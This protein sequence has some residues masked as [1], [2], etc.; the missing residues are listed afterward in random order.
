[1]G[2]YGTDSFLVKPGRKMFHVV[3]VGRG[4]EM[5]IYFGSVP[6]TPFNMCATSLNFHFLCLWIVVRGLGAYSGM[7]GC[8]VLMVWL[9]MIHGLFFR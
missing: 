9:V 2:E 4:M 8:L 7:V 1:M 6:F 5:D 3:F